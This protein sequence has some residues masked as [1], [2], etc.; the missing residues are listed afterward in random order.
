MY[1]VMSTVVPSVLIGS[2]AFLQVRRTVINSQMSSKF[3]SFLPRTVELAALEQLKKFP[4][5][6][7]GR[8]VVSTLVPSFLIGRILPLT[9]ELA[10]LEIN[11]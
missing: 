11:I 8:K 2:S 4:W 9:A 5:T 10:T 6:C 1:N 3:G 7:N